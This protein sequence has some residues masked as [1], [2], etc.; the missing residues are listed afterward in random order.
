MATMMRG[1]LPRM[2]RAP[3]P[4]SRGMAGGHG[5]GGNMDHVFGD[6]SVP[7][8]FDFQPPSMLRTFTLTLVTLAIFGAPAWIMV[9]DNMKM[10]AFLE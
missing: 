3:P 8:P 1:L 5:G 6:S 10:E 7:V 4:A 2:L 9:Y